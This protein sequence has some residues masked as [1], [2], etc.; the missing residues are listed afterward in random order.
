MECRVYEVSAHCATDD[1]G[2]PQVNGSRQGDGGR[3]AQAGGCAKER[4]HVAGILHGVEH[5]DARRIGV[6]ELIE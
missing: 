4:T 3:D 2:V 1:F 6:D 5:E